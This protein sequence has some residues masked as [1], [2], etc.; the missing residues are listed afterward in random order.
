ML[1]FEDVGGSAEDADF[2]IGLAADIITELSRSG[3]MSLI[4]RHESQSRAFAG[5]SVQE[6]G[7]ILAVRY[8]LS[9]TVRRIGERGC[10]SAELVRR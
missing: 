4:S 10:L 6:V 7:R 8:V 5:K 1:P 9:G 2:C 3:L